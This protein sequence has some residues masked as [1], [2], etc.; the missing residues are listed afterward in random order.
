MS[1]RTTIWHSRETANTQKS[2]NID[3]PKAS[4]NLTLKHMHRKLITVEVP[5][6]LLNFGL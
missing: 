1:E 3:L 4:Q 6:K 5:E 2:S